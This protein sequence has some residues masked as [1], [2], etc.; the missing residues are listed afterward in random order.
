MDIQ[1]THLE[2]WCTADKASTPRADRVP[3]RIESQG[4][5]APKQ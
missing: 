3:A 4:L 1:P 2:Q 5:G